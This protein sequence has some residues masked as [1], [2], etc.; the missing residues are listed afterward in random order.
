MKKLLSVLL[1]VTLLFALS[2]TAFAAGSP[3]KKETPPVVE[4]IEVKGEGETADG[5]AVTV[6]AWDPKAIPEGIPFKDE[7]DVVEK[8]L[9]SEAYEDL[10]KE[11]KKE[12][13]LDEKDLV[14]SSVLALSIEGEDDE[15]V[16][17]VVVIFYDGDGKPVAGMYFYEDEW[18]PL[19]V[20]VDEEA[21]E[22][23]AYVLVFGDED[24][25]DAVLQAEV[26][27]TIAEKDE[28]E[29]TAKK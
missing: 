10:V 29:D 5:K 13:K 18:Y 9:D 4:N 12:L 11:L 2:A 24:D 8:A 22:D 6:A 1:V 14:G 21:D 3:P 7:E 27:V 28:K 19:A 26:K 20:E 25:E 16:P 15:A 17:A 23:D